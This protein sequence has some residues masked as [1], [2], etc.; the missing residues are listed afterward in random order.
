MANVPKVKVGKFDPEKFESVREGYEYGGVCE[1]GWFSMGW[2]Q[3][4][5]ASIR[6]QQHQKEHET[7]TLMPDRA[8]VEALTP[9][10]FADGSTPRNPVRPPLWDEVK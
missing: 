1:C 4:K 3:R 7:G 10:A 8:D 5:Q 6:M 2:P 9:E